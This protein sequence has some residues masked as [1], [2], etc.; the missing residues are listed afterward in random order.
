MHMCMYM[1]T[2]EEDKKFFATSVARCVKA[3]M[4]FQGAEVVSPQKSVK[5]S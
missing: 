1:C 2:M 3:A 4:S 5:C